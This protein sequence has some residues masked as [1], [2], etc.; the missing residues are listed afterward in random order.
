MIT[1]T[2]VISSRFCG[3][4]QSG[5]GG[6]VCGRLA[7]HLPGPVVVRL[8]A[9]TP[10][11]VALQIEAT[12]NE[13]GLKQEATRIAEARRCALEVD[14]PTAPSFE[15]ATD[16]SR[17]YTGFVRHSFSTCFVC[18]PRRIPG[19]GMRIFPGLIRGSRVLAAPWIPDASLADASGLVLAEF[20]WAALDCAGGFAII[21][22]GLDE[23]KSIL[24]GE[25]RAR[26][27][28]TVAP[29][30]PCVVMAWP[31]GDDCRKRFACTAVVSPSGRTVAVARATWIE[32]PAADVAS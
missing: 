13:A 10:L 23:S 27:D 14:I 32:V 16:A 18:G 19:D 21:S 20:I 15:E 24:L 17:A 29:G 22:E 3:P 7:K 5:N 26:I 25:M 6:Y 30:E 8:R 2:L 31:D 11:N 9:P 4:P 12:E 28:G 1:E